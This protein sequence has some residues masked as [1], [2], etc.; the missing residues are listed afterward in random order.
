[1][2]DAVVL[3]SHLV[4]LV[5]HID[6]SECIPEVVAHNNLRLR[7]WQ[8]GL[9][10]H[11]TRAGFLRRFRAAVHQIHHLSQLNHAPSAT[12]P[13]NEGVDFDSG[14]AGGV[15][16]RIN[17]NDRS[18]QAFSAAE[19]ESRASRGSRRNSLDKG[20]FLVWQLIAMNDNALG[21]LAVSAVQFRGLS[22]VDPP[23]P[24]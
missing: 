3:H 2:V 17:V 20:Y 5:S 23:R 9:D 7:P 15:R 24:V 11:Q 10:E 14:Q 16:Q 4:G 18:L 12:M 21:R 1:M 13:S 22:G 19:I 6:T 8:A